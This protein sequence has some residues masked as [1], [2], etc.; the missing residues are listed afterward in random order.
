[1]RFYGNM[2]VPEV[3]VAMGMSTR[4]VEKQWTLTKAWMRGQLGGDEE[5]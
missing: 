5:A 2:T 4:W 3:A 1:M